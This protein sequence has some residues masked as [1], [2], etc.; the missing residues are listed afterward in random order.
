[1]KI[2]IDGRMYGMEN[3]GI[4]RYVANLICELQNMDD[5]NSYVLLLRKEYFN[6][7]NMPDRWQKVLVDTRHYSFSEQ[8]V[9]NRVLNRIKPDLVHFPHFNVPVLYKGKF[10]VTIH[11]LLMHKR[12]GA[13]TTLPLPVYFLKRVGYKTVF[14]NAVNK[15]GVVIVPTEYV[16]GEVMKMY[17]WIS[18]KMKVIYEGVDENIFKARVASGF[19]RRNRIAKPYFLYVGNVYP[20]KNVERLI[21]AACVVGKNLVIVTPRNVFRKRLDEYVRKHDAGGLVKFTGYVE[22]HDLMALYR[23]ATA[24]VYPSL[25]EG[26]GLPGLEA[27]ANKC[28]LL[29][30]DI[31]VF[32]E[33]Y[34]NH[35]IYF[36]ALYYGSIE[37][38]M[39]EA[40]QMKD[41]RKE[42]MISRAFEFVKRYSWEKMA[43]ETLRVY[44]SV[45]SDVSV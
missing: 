37:K 28:L 10:V 5:K 4:G 3:G 2:V 6:R 19:I 25:D 42:R 24:F 35:A 30:S 7:L 18:A 36:N 27:M 12:R 33:V 45:V 8:I 16:K 22:D 44:E 20:H 15:A 41:E 21:E 14:E 43:R 9:V 1:M 39:R 34:K 23:N 29:A 31:P 13:A 40:L 38:A 32:R 17:P 11:D 26:F